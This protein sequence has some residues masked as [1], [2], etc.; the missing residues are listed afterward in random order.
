MFATGKANGKRKY[1]V[2][3]LGRILD[4]YW[5]KTCPNQKHFYEVIREQTPCRLYFD[6]EY[7]KIFNP[8]ITP[9]IS[10]DLLKDFM[11]EL[12]DE[13]QSLL[14]EWDELDVD[15]I[16]LYPRLLTFFI[17]SSPFGLKTRFDWVANPLLVVP[18]ICQTP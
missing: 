16:V 15:S 9:D 11:H 2:G 7:S 5:R 3:H 13:L 4:L 14:N 1:L 12:S 18:R 8:D 6:M 10:A 17:I